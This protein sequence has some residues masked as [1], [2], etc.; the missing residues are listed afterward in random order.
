MDKQELR[1]A[2]S[3]IEDEARVLRTANGIH[4]VQSYRLSALVVRLAQLVREE[5][6][7]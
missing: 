7:K 2:L 3:E 1:N 5:I 6:V 4:A